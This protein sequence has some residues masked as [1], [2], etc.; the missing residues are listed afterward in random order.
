MTTA[1]RRAHPRHE[2]PI[3][4]LFRKDGTEATTRD[5]S[6]G[7]CAILAP[8]MRLVNERLA[9]TL[10][11]RRTGEMFEV[12]AEVKRA[13]E[14]PDGKW[15]LGVQFVGVGPD[16]QQNI[17]AFVAT[18]AARRA[19]A[20]VATTDDISVLLHAA[21]D[22][23]HGGNRAE[24]AKILDRAIA[25]APKRADILV[26]RAR[27]ASETGDLRGAANFAKRAAELEPGNSTY[28]QL[29]QRF[30]SREPGGN[31]PATG[32]PATPRPT[33]P[34]IPTDRRS[35]V[36]SAAV[37]MLLVAILGGNVWF[38]MF[39]APPGLPT[40]LDTAAYRDLVPM[41]ALAVRDGRAFGTVEA[42]WR[43]L[44]EREK[45]VTDLAAR[46]RADKINSLFL[47][48]TDARLVATHRDGA[49]RL[50]R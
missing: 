37:G 29:Y 22:A 9:L 47:S 2:H 20:S 24:A 34:F 48:D 18:L 33:K 32:A 7:G 50:F 41:S 38:W 13:I 17:A 28:A 11:D 30:T 31:S 45:R 43:S 4:V 19:S 35:L 40:Q 16:V 21:S 12:D 15:L 36:L 14:M 6:L 25:A 23:E 27:I 10:G 49:T 46:L 5:I 42:D 39:R 26:T 1:D 44:P 8:R 3:D